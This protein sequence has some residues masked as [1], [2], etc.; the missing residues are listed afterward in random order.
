MFHNIS[1]SIF[2][3]EYILLFHGKHY[4]YKCDMQGNLGDPGPLPLEI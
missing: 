2:Y 3:F 4:R 1:T